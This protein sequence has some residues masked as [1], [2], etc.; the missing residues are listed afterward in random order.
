MPG[1]FSRAKAKADFCTMLSYPDPQLPFILDTDASDF[2]IGA[3][4]SQQ[5]GEHEKVVAYASCALTKTERR[6]A[7]TKK[8]LLAVVAF[9]RHFK[10][11]LLGRPFT[12]RTDHSSLR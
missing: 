12:L 9:T 11:L 6:Y 3:V 4:L 7:V 2:G 8:A 1:F 10:H 5:H